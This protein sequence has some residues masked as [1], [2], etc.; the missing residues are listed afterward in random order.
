MCPHHNPTAVIEE[1]DKAHPYHI[2]CKNSRFANLQLNTKA[3]SISTEHKAT[4]SETFINGR[5]KHRGQMI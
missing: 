1:A 3:K 2:G 4:K 5:V